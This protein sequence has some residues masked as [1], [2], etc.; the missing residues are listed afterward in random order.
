MKCDFREMAQQYHKMLFQDMV[1]YVNCKI[2]KDEEDV[3]KIIGYCESNMFHGACLICIQGLLMTN[4]KSCPE[5]RAR[6]VLEVPVDVGHL[7]AEEDDAAAGPSRSPSPPPHAHFERPY[8]PTS[9]SYSPTSPSYLPTSP[10]FSPTSPSYSPPTS[11][12]YTAPSFDDADWTDFEPNP[13]KRQRCYSPT[14][15]D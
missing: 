2:C 10:S 1:M 11:P 7:R 15:E 8:S 12:T 14:S 4:A 3:C 13:F 5:C 9:R 6:L